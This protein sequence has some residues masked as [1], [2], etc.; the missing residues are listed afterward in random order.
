MTPAELRQRLAEGGPLLG[1]LLRLPA[2]SLV[3]MVGIAGLDCVLLDLEHGPAD[4]VSV[5]HHVVA[6]QVHGVPTLVRVGADE[7]AL[8]LRCLDLG[9]AGI[10]FPHISSVDDAR[11]AVAAAHYPPLGQRGFASYTRA[12]RY[13]DA[14]SA[15]HLDAGADTVV[16]VMIEDAA[17]CAAAAEILA[18]DGVDGVFVGPA[19]L[20]VA[21]GHRGDA[22]HPDVLAAS[23]D[24]HE[25]AAKASRAVVR[26]VASPELALDAFGAGASLVLYNT[27]AVL[28]DTFRRLAAARRP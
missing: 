3:E 7:P 20:S 19:D 15:E 27:A 8:V 14:A 16:I 6:A 12:G 11:R 17:G 23:R 9:V 21:L 25:A 1:A 13:G 4:L 2:E 5:Q 10:V 28:T 18:V 24:V 26:I 22:Q